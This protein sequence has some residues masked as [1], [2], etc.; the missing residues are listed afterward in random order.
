MRKHAGNRKRRKTGSQGRRGLS[1]F[2]CLLALMILGGSLFVMTELTRIGMKRGVHSRELIEA[3]LHCESLMNE[4]AAGS[5]APV[6]VTDE[7]IEDDPA[8]LHSITVDQVDQSGLLTVTVTVRSDVEN[9]KPTEFSL[10]RWI[11]DP[12]TEVAEAPRVP[13]PE[14]TATG[15]SATQGGAT[16]Q[17]AQQSFGPTAGAPGVGGAPGT[18]Q[19]GGFG[20]PGAGGPGAG[21]PGQGGPGQGGRPGGGNGGGRPGGGQGGFGGGRPGG[22]GGPGGGGFP[23]GGGGRPGGGGGGFPGGGGGGFGGGGFGGGGGGRPG[24]AGS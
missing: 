7:P 2:E 4:L 22:G 8:W 5:L 3:Q 16:G 1:L 23:G 14:T 18:N 20:A 11:V 12:E 15:G 17:P 19:A 21:G 10:T 24:G 6:A 13:E 9:P